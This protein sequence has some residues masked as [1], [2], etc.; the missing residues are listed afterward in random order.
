MTLFATVTD[1]ELREQA[2][3]ALLGDHAEKVIR[4]VIAQRFRRG[5]IG[6]LRD[7]D[8]EDLGAVAMLRVLQRLRSADDPG[9]AAIADFDAYVATVTLHA[10]DDLLRERMP[11][12]T[13][14]KNRLCYI[15]H[16]DP[17]F[18]QWTIGEEGVCGRVEW[19]AIR[20]VTRTVSLEGVRHLA[21]SRDVRR[22]LEAIFA[23][24]GEPVELE[25]VVNA[26]AELWQM[27]DRSPV[28]LDDTVTPSIPSHARE[29]EERQFLGRLW[30]EIGLLNRPQRVALILNLRDESGPAAELFPLLGVATIRDIA[31]SV[32]MPPGEFAPIWRELPLGDL[33]IASI[34]GVTRQQ[35][36]NLRKSARERLRR[37]MRC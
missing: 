35:V 2:L 18:A 16:R 4:R 3:E 36:I 7:D 21:S 30:S 33:R 5:R 34:L 10:C 31:D 1:H 8:R 25:A 6:A 24:A 22:L 9:G 20:T 12:R 17:R 37:R 11:K 32:G 28:A 14:A 29:T 23:A 26:A 27:N 13:A 15:L 19:R